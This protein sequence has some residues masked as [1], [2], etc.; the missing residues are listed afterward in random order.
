MKKIIFSLVCLCMALLVFTASAQGVWEKIQVDVNDVN[1]TVDGKFVFARNFV[2]EGTTYLSLRDMGTVL[3]YEVGWDDETKTASLTSGDVIEYK[4]TP[5]EKSTETI[6]VLVNDVKVVVD[7]K[8]IDARNLV[9]ND[10]TYLSLRDIGNATGFDVYWDEPSFTA[11]LTSPGNDRIIPSELTLNEILVAEVDGV[12]IPAI[13]LNDAYFYAVEVVSQDQLSSFVKYQADYYAYVLKE[14]QRLGITLSEDDTKL[15]GESFEEVVEM[16]GGKEEVEKILA[17]NNFSYEQYEKEFNQIMTM[18]ALSVKLN[19]YIEENDDEIKALKQEAEAKYQTEKS[20]YTYKTVTVK[21]ILIP[22]SEAETKESTLQRATEVLNK[23]NRGERFEKLLE[24]NNND[25]GQTDEGYEVYEGS[26]FVKE[27]EEASLKLE[28][29]QTSP[30]VETVYGYH[31]IKAIDTAQE[32]IT[33]EEYINNSTFAE[34]INA[35]YESLFTNW[36]ENVEASYG[37]MM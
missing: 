13:Y 6:S 25:P 26:G 20:N 34:E 18:N 37:W 17:Q 24:K 32:D 36:L 1:V 29:G 22:F 27:F 10:T 31:I 16:N 23:L 12:E 9:Y 28:K 11:V 19:E 14:C 5:G 15:F 7:G 21:H 30:L 35:V 2:H 3:G 4:F 8:L 33:L